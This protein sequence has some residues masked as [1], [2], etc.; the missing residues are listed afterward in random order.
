MGLSA[1]HRSGHGTP[2]AP[3]TPSRINAHAIAGASPSTTISRSRALDPVWIAD[4]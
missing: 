1:Q 3:D 4:T 2:R